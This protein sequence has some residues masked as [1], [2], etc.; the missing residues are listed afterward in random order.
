MARVYENKPFIDRYDGEDEEGYIEYLHQGLPLL[1]YDHLLDGR[2]YYFRLIQAGDD[3]SGLVE[4][5][6]RRLA[7]IGAEM[8]R[9]L[10][11]AER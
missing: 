7:V 10:N 3:I 2:D 1:S 5:F 8:L 6:G 4:I 9:R 11:I